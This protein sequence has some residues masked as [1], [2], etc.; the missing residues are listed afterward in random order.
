LSC[1]RGL[2]S[3]PGA[4]GVGRAST[5]AFVIS[6]VVILILDF[7]LGMFFI[8]LYQHLWPDA[9]GKLL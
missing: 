2:N 8:N 3:R 6:F 1:H 9:G 5:E 7:F 4:E